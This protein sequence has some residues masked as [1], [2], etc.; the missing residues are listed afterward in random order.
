MMKHA[1]FHVEH[2]VETRP[3]FSRTMGHKTRALL[4]WC[5]KQRTSFW[6][7]D[8]ADAITDYNG[9]ELV[10]INNGGSKVELESTQGALTGAST[11]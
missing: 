2:F 8:T 5:V 10:K 3:Q 4:G 6:N 11:C 9:V 1:I 7:Y